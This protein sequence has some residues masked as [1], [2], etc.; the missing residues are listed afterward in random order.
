MFPFQ[1]SD[2]SFSEFQFSDFVYVN[3]FGAR[4]AVHM[5]IIVPNMETDKIHPKTDKVIT[6][7]SPSLLSQYGKY[8]SFAKSSHHF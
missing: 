3:N 5:E 8:V 4:W 2:F 7:I 1:F 6:N